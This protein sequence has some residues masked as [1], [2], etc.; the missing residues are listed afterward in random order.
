VA[1]LL[2]RGCQ[3]G[4]LALRHSPCC[5]ECVLKIG[6]I[7][8]VFAS[9]G[10]GAPKLQPTFVSEVNTPDAS[11]IL[12]LLT[13]ACGDGVRTVTAK[14]KTALGCGDG[15]MDEILASRKRGR[16][17]PWMPYVLWQA[18]GVIF[19]HFLSPTSED[20]AVNCFACDGHAEL[21]GGTLL[22]TKK[23]GEW[24][25][26]W[27]KAGVITRHC[28]RVSL[29]TGRQILFC[30]ETDGGMGHSIHGIYIVDFAKPRF[31]WDSVVLMADSYSDAMLGGVQKQSIDRVTFE[32]GDGGEVLIRVYARHGRVKLRPEQDGEHLPIPKLSS[33]EIDFRL[34]AGMFKVT[35]ETAAAAKL[36]G[37]S[38]R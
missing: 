14:G 6:W 8:L 19:G 17:Y 2:F 35:N 3:N 5:N 32:D 26:V 36:F 7:I 37:L 4:P 15:S 24:E 23:S 21:Y 30:E 31:A 22:L 11:I 33:Y 16:R 27:Y 13:A 12:P 10:W 29:A 18:D 1:P 34:N 25:P 20:A 38:A 28:R 9:S